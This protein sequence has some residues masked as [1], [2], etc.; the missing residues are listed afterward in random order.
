MQTKILNFE[1]CIFSPLIWPTDFTLKGSMY[2]HKNSI[3]I[4]LV[5]RHTSPLSVLSVHWCSSYISKSEEMFNILMLLMSKMLGTYYSVLG[6][7][8]FNY[9]QKYD[10]VFFV[11]FHNSLSF[12]QSNSQKNTLLQYVILT[13]LW[14]RL[15]SCSEFSM[16]W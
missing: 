4:V 7:L 8:I 10:L 6:I 15:G 13:P 9:I 5:G 11:L 2:E 14:R 3:K 12:R 16:Q 1:I